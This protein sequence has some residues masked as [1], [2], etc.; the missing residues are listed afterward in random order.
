MVREP[1]LTPMAA[2]RRLGV[3]RRKVYELIE[4]GHLKAHDRSPGKLRRTWVIYER[5]IEAKQ[6][7]LEMRRARLERQYAALEATLGRLQS[8]S[9]FVSAQI[10]ATFGNRTS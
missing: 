4:E 2:A 1:L 6:E 8:Q 9:Q 10:D 3:S 5:D 7:A